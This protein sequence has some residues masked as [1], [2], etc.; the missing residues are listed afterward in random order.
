MELALR[1]QLAEASS[2]QRL[3]ESRRQQERTDHAVAVAAAASSAAIDRSASESVRAHTH[4]PPT[5][6]GAHRWGRAPAVMTVDDA[7][8]VVR[9]HC[10]CDVFLWVLLY[11]PLGAIA[12]VGFLAP[13]AGIIAA[14]RRNQAHDCRQ[15]LV[16]LHLVAAIGAAFLR[17]VVA[18]WRTDNFLFATTAV[19]LAFVS[20]HQF[21]LGVIFLRLLRAHRRFGG[22]SGPGAVPTTG[23]RDEATPLS[24]AWPMVTAVATADT[25]A[26]VASAVPV[27]RTA[28]VVVVDGMP[29]SAAHV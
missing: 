18:P 27:G 5:A 21:W 4:N 6:A 8:D 23:T 14:T 28:P 22:R 16:A 25:Y 17:G 19:C 12:T 26:G 7:A 9:W 1:L 13:F 10:G 20:V 29:V 3:E 15:A 11:P 2:S 24:T